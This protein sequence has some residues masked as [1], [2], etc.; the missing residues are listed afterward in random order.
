VTWSIFTALLVGVL[1][2]GVFFLGYFAVNS[3]ARPSSILLA[4]LG[5]VV[6]YSFH[7][8]AMVL[9]LSDLR[10]PAPLS[11]GA[12]SFKF[13]LALALMTGTVLVIALLYGAGRAIGRE[14]TGPAWLRGLHGTKVAFPYSAITFVASYGVRFRAP[15]LPAPVGGALTVHPSHLAAFLWPLALGVIFGFAG[16]FRSPA[17]VGLGTGAWDRRIR[18][19]LYGGRRMI[20]YGLFFGFVS[21]L[22]MGAVHP[23]ITADYFHGAFHAG[24]LRGL[25]IVYAHSLVIPN[26]AAWVLFPSMGTCLGLNGGPIS[27]CALSY[28][29]FPTSRITSTPGGIAGLPFSLPQFPG[30]PV[31]YY[32]FVAIP[33]LAVLLGGMAAAKRSGALTRGEA[34]GVGAM[35]G[36]AFALFALGTLLL[37]SIR[38]KVGGSLGAVSQLVGT[39][40]GPD[41]ASGTL[42]ALVW[43]VVG[44]ALGGLYGGRALARRMPAPAGPAWQPS[45]PPASEPVSS[46]PPEPGGPGPSGQGD[47]GET[48]PSPDA[49]PTAPAPP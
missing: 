16:G 37:A 49:G 47:P 30:P 41:L 32:A 4:R 19:A 2:E 28:T 45:P 3:A 18:G 43:G 9:D 26:M 13:T 48:P 31:V 17:A 20:G 35:S 23:D 34:V 36:V 11:G 42:L 10:L 33:L 39:R 8:V 38:F 21:L 46:T 14:V 22:G 25:T 12:V 7:H 40:V 1:A 27:I 24:V 5:G 6:F 15:Q 29:H 44:G